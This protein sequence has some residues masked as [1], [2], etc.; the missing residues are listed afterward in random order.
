ME[1]HER[2]EGAGLGPGGLAETAWKDI[3]LP[4]CYLLIASGQLARVPPEGIGPAGSPLI[5]LSSR[6]DCR[7]ARVSNNPA[8]PLAVL[9]AIASKRGYRVDF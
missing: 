2:R 9:R 8:E 4:G 3:R 6:G 5:S 7:V 1:Q